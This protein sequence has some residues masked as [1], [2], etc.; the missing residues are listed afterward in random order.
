MSKENQIPT[1]EEFLRQK[2]FIHGMTR[3]DQ[4]IA[5]IE[6]AKLH[7]KQALKKAS[8]KANLTDFACEF[9]QEGSTN[10]IDKESILK[11]YPENLIK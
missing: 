7:V 2:P 3:S 8:E 10:A 11:A 4:I 6:F 9:L 5:M 1:A